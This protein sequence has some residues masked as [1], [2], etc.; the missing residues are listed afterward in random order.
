ME[1]SVDPTVVT[2]V[3]TPPHTMTL[4]SRLRRLRRPVAFGVLV[5]TLVASAGIAGGAQ[6]PA[7]KLS[8]QEQAAQL[9][10]QIEAS[11]IEIGGLGERLHEAEAQRD[12]A[13]QHA[14]DA[15]AQ[16]AQARQEVERIM[17]LVRANL[18]S[19]Y[20]RSL[21]G[22]STSELDFSAT[23][24]LLKRGQ[25]AKAQ[26][27]KDDELIQKLAAA[28]QD[29]D[30][31]RTTAKQARDAAAAEGQKIAD[32]KAAVEGA[33]AQQQ[34]VLDQIKGELAAAVAAEQARR[35]AA[36]AQALATKPSGSE[37][38]PDVGPPNGSASQAIAFARA[39][40]GAGYSNKSDRMG[41]ENYDCSGLT[42]MAWRAAGVS[43][44]TVS[45]TQYAGLPHVPLNAIQPGDLIFY[46]PAGS[47]HVAL[48]IGGGQIIDASSSQNQV[49]LRG[50]WGSPIGAARVV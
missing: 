41:P 18:A 6:T 12:A 49:S 32:A 5:A 39:A 44:P 3:H 1:S 46:G 38:Y 22:D 48:Y 25:Y 21:R 42:T 2:D 35:A 24:D 33:R 50:I 27:D 28:Q 4:T 10:D 37:K 23:V 9:Q 14:L 31:E 8:K 26:A 7:P 30:L 34:A 29:L 15:E 40:V 19:L 17:T 13:Q 36:A 47:A 45:T 20:R 11:D 43:I 16:I